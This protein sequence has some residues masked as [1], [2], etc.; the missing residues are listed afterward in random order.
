[1]WYRRS[2]SACK[3]PSISQRC[4]NCLQSRRVH[5]TG[6]QRR[7]PAANAISVIAQVTRALLGE[8]LSFFHRYLRSRISSRFAWT[9]NSAQPHIIYDAH[10][11]FEVPNERGYPRDGSARP[12]SA[13]VGGRQVRHRYLQHSLLTQDVGQAGLRFF[14]RPAVQ[15]R[16]ALPAVSD[17]RPRCL[18]AEQDRSIGPIDVRSAGGR[19]INVCA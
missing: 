18:G 3:W 5:C 6:A 14:R 9:E 19:I 15:A 7:A 1:M 8:N 4:D 13:A 16:R 2:Q 17:F 12:F 11:C 10:Y